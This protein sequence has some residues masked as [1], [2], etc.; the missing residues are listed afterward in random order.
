MANIKLPAD[1]QLV[2]GTT[3]DDVVTLTG[4]ID[5]TDQL[6]HDGNGGSDT[7]VLGQGL[8]AFVGAELDRVSYVGGSTMEWTLDDDT[9]GGTAADVITLTNGFTKV[10]FADGAVLESGVASVHNP[11][12]TDGTFTGAAGSELTYRWDGSNLTA[13]T[14]LTNAHTII[15]VDGSVIADAGTAFNNDDGQFSIVD[16]AGATS[17]AF[18]ASDAAL[19]AAGNVDD[20]ASFTYDIVVEDANGVQ[21][22]IPVTFTETIPFTSGDDTWVASTSNATVDETGSE[23][24]GNDT[25]TGHEGVDNITAGDG[26]DSLSGG[27]DND[28]LAGGDGDDLILGENGNDQINGGTGDNIIRGGNGNDVITAAAGGASDDNLLG[29]GAG[30][31]EITG[32][33]GNDTIFGGNGDDAANNGL[34]GGAGND[35]ING[36]AGADLLNGGDGNDTLK[37][38]DGND[39]LNGGADNDEL[40]GGA[41]KDDVDGG[42]GD[43]VIHTS[44]GGDDLL[45]GLGNDTFVLKAGTGETTIEDFGAGTDLL[46]ISDLVDGGMTLAD[47]LANAYEVDATPGAANGTYVVLQIDADTSVA[48]QNTT[49][50]TLASLDAGDFIV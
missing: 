42:A 44:L 48:L 23:D 32:G 24:D 31:D 25:F 1:D 38:G 6:T 7:L 17:V 33:D 3:G 39:V 2:K 13:D 28:V 34:A 36:G 35:V 4:T 30:N 45:G 43:D 46:D 50:V 16:G 37:G 29:G 26:N 41:G 8:A 49:D 15:S 47:L 11:I 5:G 14:A 20:T 18:T 10:Q 27:D 22:T 9:A 21:S 40:R 19:R 12:V